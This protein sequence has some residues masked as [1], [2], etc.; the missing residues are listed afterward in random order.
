MRK[1]A[2]LLLVLVFLTASCLIVAKPA[3]SSAS[4]AENTWATKAPLHQA[5][6]GLGVAAVNGKIYAIGGN[7]ESGLY[8]ALVN[9][10]FVGTNEEYDI[11]TDT[12]TTKTP[13]PTPRAFFAI[14]VYQNKIY[15]IGGII[16]IGQG[17]YDGTSVLLPMHILSGVNEVYDPATDTWE[18]K[19]SMPTP[20]MN[21]HAN[22][23]GNG[24]YIMDGFDQ[25]EAPNEVYD[26]ATDTWTTKTPMPPTGRN[27]ASA[28]V[29][30]WSQGTP[31]P[32]IVID[33]AAVATTGV[34]APKRIYVIGVQPGNNPLTINY[35]YDPES[36]NWMT[37]ATMS[38]NRIDFG[39]VIVNDKL[40]AIGGYTF[41]NSPNNGKVTVSAVNEEYTPFGYGTAPP[42]I[43]VVSP[44]NKNYTSSNVSLTFTLNKPS[45]WMG[46]SLD[47]RETV[48]ISGN[49]TIAGLPNGLHNVTVYAKDSFENTG[50]S[51]TT[52][53]S[54]EVPFPTALVAA[55]VVAIVA[56]GSGFSAVYYLRKRKNKH[57]T[58]P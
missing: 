24:L 19:T 40:Y 3:F 20:R 14:A 54:V 47:G 1:S 43:A 26:P 7:T 23:A 39:A 12:W 42:A 53:F 38:T 27:Y 32:S 58:P 48:T 9:G 57:P 44:E 37:G 6:A 41:D 51:E 49:T 21:I 4:E 15:C 33:G 22:V 30:S 18:N 34:V 11:A 29:D 28:V 55:T 16:G 56:T 8:P 35:V 45:V 25:V 36:D 52:S 10:E 5:R 46:Y 31:A 17:F 2:A 50:A 13:M